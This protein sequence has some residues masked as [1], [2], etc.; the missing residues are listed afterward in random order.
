[1]TVLTLYLLG[2]LSTS[3]GAKAP[4]PEAYKAQIEAWR[5]QRVAALRA[6]DGWLTVAGLFWLKPGPNTVGAAPDNKIVLPAGSAPAHLGVFDF[7]GGQTSFQAAPGAQV[8]VD[9][10]LATSAALKPDSSGSPDMLRVNDLTMFVI[11]RGDWY[12]VRLRDKNSKIRRE[13]KDVRYFPIREQYRVVARF[14]PYNPPKKMAIPNILGQIDQ[15][16]GPGYAEF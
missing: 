8:T 7:S 9:G 15:A 6:D 3:I 5:K 10:K 16:T 13:F 1:M 14:V 2:V 4:S 11:Q 12:G